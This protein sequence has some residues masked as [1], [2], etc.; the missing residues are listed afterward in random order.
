MLDPSFSWAMGWHC[1]SVSAP[2]AA[3]QVPSSPYVFAFDLTCYSAPVG[4]MLTTLT[5]AILIRKVDG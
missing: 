1:L 2:D 4:T 3:S 5:H